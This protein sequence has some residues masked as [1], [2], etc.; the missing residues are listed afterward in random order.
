MEPS[1]FLTNLRFEIDEKREE[2]KR[3]YEVTAL[4]KRRARV[5]LKIPW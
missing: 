2:S 4:M 1:K 3:L 5:S